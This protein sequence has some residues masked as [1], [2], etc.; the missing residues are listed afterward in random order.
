MK[1]AF[2][3]GGGAALVG[4]ATLASCGVGSPSEVVGKSSQAITNYY[5]VPGPGGSLTVTTPDPGKPTGPGDPNPRD[6][7]PSYC[8]FVRLKGPLAFSD[9]FVKI[10]INASGHWFGQ[11]KRLGAM[12]FKM[13]CTRFADFLH[14][15]N[16]VTEGYSIKGSAQANNGVVAPIL[17]DVPSNVSYRTPSFTPLTVV[18]GNFSR[19]YPN[20]NYDQ[21]A[22]AFPI[23]QPANRTTDVT[24]L[25]AQGVWCPQV[26]GSPA[27]NPTPH[28]A[29]AGAIKAVG[30][31]QTAWSGGNGPIRF[32]PVGFSD[33][34][35]YEMMP[36]ADGVCWISSID[37]HFQWAE[38]AVV[39]DKVNASGVH[40]WALKST[41]P[42]SSYAQCIKYEQQ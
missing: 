20:C 39:Y 34:A 31:S 2:F 33:P 25:T 30:H 13:G 12:E 17:A 38:E 24:T 36:V 23:T 42:G 10:D 15:G 22:S 3:G 8:Y 41:T 35:G 26:T 18:V 11:V 32:G 40:V 27:S 37:Y 29:Y 9:D 16:A 1:K 4:F 21:V 6:P 5:D 19:P 14:A 28:G 7:D